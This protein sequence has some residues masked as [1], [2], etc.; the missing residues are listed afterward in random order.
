[1]FLDP[2]LDVFGQPHLHA[3]KFLVQASGSDHQR[4]SLADG[5][6]MTVH[7]PVPPLSSCVASVWVPLWETANRKSEQKPDTTY[8]DN[9]PRNALSGFECPVCGSWVTNP[10][11][12]IVLHTVQ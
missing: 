2:L 7:R 4:R 1:M 12:H 9:H 6:G 3:P 10:S 11:R 8:P 5:G